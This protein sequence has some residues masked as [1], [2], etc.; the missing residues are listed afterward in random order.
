M[1]DLIPTDFIGFQPLAV[2][3]PPWVVY[4][5]LIMMG[6]VFAIVTGFLVIRF[7]LSLLK[8]LL[9]VAIEGLGV[10]AGLAVVR[11]LFEFTHVSLKVGDAFALVLWG[12]AAGVI[13]M[14]II[15]VVAFITILLRA[16]HK[17]GPEMAICVMKSMLFGD[18]RI[19]AFQ[20]I[21]AR[22]EADHVWDQFSVGAL[23]F[24]SALDGASI[25]NTAITM[26]PNTTMSHAGMMLDGAIKQ[27]VTEFNAVVSKTA[28]RFSVWRICQASN[29]CERV[30][31]STDNDPAGNVPIF[32]RESGPVAPASVGCQCM[33]AKKPVAVSAANRLPKG[34]PKGRLG[35]TYSAFR[36]EP[37]FRDGDE[38][39]WGYV[40][41]DLVEGVFD[42]E[43][44]G[45]ARVSSSLVDAIAPLS[46]TFKL[47]DLGE[48][49]NDSPQGRQPP[50]ADKS[51][52]SV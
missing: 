31:V 2:G 47:R 36:C 45:L 21:R 25:M 1:V 15:P 7:N 38:W 35:R 33:L 19:G 43:S 34:F 46:P 8:L 10:P 48:L 37:I 40:C 17:W 11:S 41:V 44:K 30:W 51:M 3:A 24:E 6:A 42:I 49:I 29:E 52:E 27:A 18:D 5:A 23:K 13:I 4:G 32:N 22:I 12:Y 14:M 28:W 20:Q 9:A 50:R 16:M 26:V 39:P